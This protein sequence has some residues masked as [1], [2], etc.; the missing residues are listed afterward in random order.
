M[1][2][3]APWMATADALDPFVKTN[4]WTILCHRIEHV[5]AARG[6]KTTMPAHEMSQ[7]R[8][9]SRDHE[10]DTPGCHRIDDLHYNIIMKKV[11]FPKFVICFFAHNGIIFF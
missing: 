11:F 9:I 10:I 5:L 2:A 3:T 8:A 4:P 6:L 7:G 1:P